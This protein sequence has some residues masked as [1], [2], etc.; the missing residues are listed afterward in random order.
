LIGPIYGVNAINGSKKFSS[1]L[2]ETHYFLFPDAV[3]NKCWLKM[4]LEDFIVLSKNFAAFFTAGIILWF[5]LLELIP[6]QTFQW[7]KYNAAIWSGLLGGSLH[8]I[9]GSDHLASLFPV[10]IAQQWYVGA[11]Y[12]LVWG[13]GHG[14][15]S[16]MAG[17]IGFTMKRFLIQPSMYLQRYRFVG[18][19]IT[20]LTISVIGITG[21]MEN[22]KPANDD[23]EKLTKDLEDQ[24]SVPIINTSFTTTARYYT[25]VKLLSVFVHGVVLGISLDGLPSLAPSIL[26][27]DTMVI[28]FLLSYLV[29]TALTM[30]TAASMLAASTSYL[31]H[32]LHSSHN[33]NNNNNT[34]NNNNNNSNNN[35]HST[36]NTS[37]KN[38]YEERLA[39]WSSYA[40]IVI[41]SIYLVSGIIRFT[42]YLLQSNN[43]N[44]INNNN[45]GTNLLMTLENNNNNDGTV[46]GSNDDQSSSLIGNKNDFLDSLLGFTSL[47][48]I[49]CTLLGSFG[50]VENKL[51]N[52][53]SGGSS[54][55][56]RVCRIFYLIFGKKWKT[57][58]DSILIQ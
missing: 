58:D 19:L 2:V 49:L 57:E 16:F 37:S 32:A 28:V 15:T 9:T 54:S 35:T 5:L 23:D 30:S 20:G 40:A 12:G 36:D 21:I 13:T 38:K 29:S 34:N 55:V 17:L 27:D 3:T 51:T 43:N 24:V 33:N 18:D 50:F 6:I 4:I 42:V 48:L 26:L 44:N 53:N 47:F 45:D 10:V 8:A 46:I 1:L 52:N 41:G 31:S 11:S 39:S 7:E 14:I 25:I 22:S 56:L